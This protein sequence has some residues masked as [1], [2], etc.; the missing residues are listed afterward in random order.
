MPRFLDFLLSGALNRIAD[1]S[2]VV[3][4]DL[5]VKNTKGLRIIDASVIVSVLLFQRMLFVS[6][7]LTFHSISLAVHSCGS[8]SGMWQSPGDDAFD[9]LTPILN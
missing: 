1:L 9:E 7:G 6:R 5:R 3:N 8:Y 4:P 2:T